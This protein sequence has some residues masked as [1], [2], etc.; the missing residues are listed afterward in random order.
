MNMAPELESVS[1]NIQGSDWEV[2]QEVNID[3]IG[4]VHEVLDR[5]DSIHIVI[6]NGRII[7]IEKDQNSRSMEWK[8]YRNGQEFLGP[9]ANEP[10]LDGDVLLLDYVPVMIM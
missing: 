3:T 1:I 4:Y 5:L 6:D 7:L 10:L 2:S 8:A 9:Y